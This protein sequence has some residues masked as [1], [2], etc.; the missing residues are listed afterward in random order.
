MIVD[1]KRIHYQIIDSIGNIEYYNEDSIPVSIVKL[2]N[3]NRP[4]KTW[5][6]ENK[7]FFQ[8]HF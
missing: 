1:N 6:R 7:R 4:D 5:T 8:Y 2:M 3:Y